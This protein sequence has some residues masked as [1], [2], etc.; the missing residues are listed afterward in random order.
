MDTNLDAELDKIRSDMVK[1][2]LKVKKSTHKEQLSNS[3]ISIDNILK[4]IKPEVKSER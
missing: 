3:I 1:L 4:D 2:L